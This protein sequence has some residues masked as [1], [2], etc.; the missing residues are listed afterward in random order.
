MFSSISCC[1]FGYT[2]ERLHY[3]V[4]LVMGIILA[5]L[6]GFSTFNIFSE[7]FNKNEN[8]IICAEPE[9]VLQYLALSFSKRNIWSYYFKV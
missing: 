1:A 8:N 9:K 4:K 5:T 7:K 6:I 2:E 3:L